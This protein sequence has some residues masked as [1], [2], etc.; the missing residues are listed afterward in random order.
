[1]SLSKTKWIHNATAEKICEKNVVPLLRILH[2]KVI[3]SW[4][5]A[6]K[7]TP[8]I[9]SFWQIQIDFTSTIK[10]FDCYEIN[11]WSTSI[12]KLSIRSV[13][14][15]QIYF[16]KL[17]N[18]IQQR[19]FVFIFYSKCEYH[20]VYLYV[21]LF[22][23]KR[24]IQFKNGL[25]HSALFIQHGMYLYTPFFWS[26]FVDSSTMFIYD[27]NRFIWNIVTIS[28]LFNNILLD[29]LSCFLM[30]GQKSLHLILSF[31]TSQY[32]QYID[33]QFYI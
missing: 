10:R 12:N 24:S 8:T 31:Q 21:D 3:K 20:S 2:H 4:Q 15:F 19:K 9:Q 33:I 25:Y 27:I 11:N 22:V 28:L 29:F 30:F 13:K 7:T 26:F 18:V 32:L 1:M 14:K 23:F 5:N 6:N 16:G 17:W